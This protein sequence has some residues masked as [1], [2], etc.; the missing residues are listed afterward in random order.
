[1]PCPTEIPTDLHSG[2]IVVLLPDR[3]NPVDGPGNQAPPPDGCRYPLARPVIPPG[4]GVVPEPRERDAPITGPRL[5]RRGNH[6]ALGGGR[7]GG[8]NRGSTPAAN[9]MAPFA[10]YAGSPRIGA[11]SPASRI[12]HQRA[13]RPR[14]TDR[15][16][17]FQAWRPIT[18][19]ASAASL[20]AMTYRCQ[21]L[22]WAR[23]VV[24]AMACSTA[25][26]TAP[27]RPPEGIRQPD[28][29]LGQ[30]AFRPPFRPP[31]R[32]PVR[33]VGL[34]QVPLEVLPQLVLDRHAQQPLPCP[35]PI[36]WVG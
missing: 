36:A 6:P 30:R 11:P 10:L 35:G 13:R 33:V 1:M 25:A 5:W 12:C 9:V 28:P 19:S 16:R 21:A 22:S 4:Q 26:G 8:G 3:A 24:A 2:Q 29:R 20:A 27:K 7:A 17:G 32:S 23:S 14:R 18:R 31:F 15:A 34:H